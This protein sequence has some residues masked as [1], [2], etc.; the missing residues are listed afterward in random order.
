M[1]LKVM[2]RW[3]TYSV[4]GLAAVVVL[5]AVATPNLLRSRLAADQARH[6]NAAPPAYLAEAAANQVPPAGSFVL[7]DERK[8]VASGSLALLVND[9][10]A[11][12]E[13][14]RAAAQAAGGY[15][16]DMNLARSDGEI[17]QATLHLRVPAAR[18][19]AVRAALRALGG[20]VENER[21]E[22]R[23]VTAEYVDL[24]AA[25]RNFRAE[26]AQYLGIMQRAGSI[27]DTL[28][29]AHRLADVRGRIERTQGRLNLL[30]HQVAMA[31][32]EV[33][34]RSEVVAPPAVTP[35]WQPLARA[36]AA[37]WDAAENLAAWFDTVVAL[38]LQLP[39]LLLWLFT[40]AGSAALGWRVLRWM[41]RKWFAPA[42]A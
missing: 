16:E 35:R 20:K 26:E 30:D 12:V 6:Y 7:P 24:S 25:L 10:A 38:A 27:K 18:F 14:V 11:V 9:V 31:S 40:V 29:V 5:L 1:Q 34:L 8:V 4:V 22:A 3:F 21:L 32:L 13:R 28:E 19:D 37:F 33:T 15:V 41:W 17:R 42:L 2:Q 36:R 39:V 23:E